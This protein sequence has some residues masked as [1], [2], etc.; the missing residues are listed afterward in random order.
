MKIR[1]EHL[2]I[3]REYLIARNA[4]ARDG[5]L[6]LRARGLLM[7]LLSHKAGWNVSL[8]TLTH[9]NPEGREAI[10]GAIAE[11]EAYG[12]LRREQTRKGTRFGAMDYI[13]SEPPITGVGKPDDGHST[14]SRSTGPRKAVTRKSAHK[15]DYVEEDQQEEDQDSTHAASAAVRAAEPK[16]KTATPDNEPTGQQRED[17]ETLCTLLADRIEDNGSKRPPVTAGWR[18]AARLML[19]EDGRTPEQVAWIIRWAQNHP[20]WR[21]RTRQMHSIRR[22]FETMRDQAREE[23]ALP[24]AVAAPTYPEPAQPAGPPCED[25]PTEPARACRSCKADVLSGDRP[26]DMIGRALHASA[27]DAQKHQEHAA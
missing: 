25:H 6:S 2:S 5:R 27:S 20:F 14:G 1:R 10:R 15:E 9:E 17:V 7:L 22:S 24:M 18:E 19:D 8:N 21:S 26:P 12:Y 3:D 16:P 23:P 4:W 13:I 11:L